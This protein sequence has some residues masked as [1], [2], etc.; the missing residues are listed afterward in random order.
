MPCGGQAPLIIRS[1]GTFWFQVKSLRL[2]S[3]CL[4]EHVRMLINRVLVCLLRRCPRRKGVKSR[5][6]FVEEVSVHIRV[7]LLLDLTVVASALTLVL[8]RQD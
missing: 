1:D 4:Q 6:R 3:S 2:N 5:V 8:R 7:L